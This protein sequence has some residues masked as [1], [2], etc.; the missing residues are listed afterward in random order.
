MQFRVQVYDYNGRTIEDRIVDL[1]CDTVEEA[2]R[3]S[4]VAKL[5]REAKMEGKGFRV[6][7]ES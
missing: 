3:D 5:K 7:K 2:M 6:I 4:K 1:P